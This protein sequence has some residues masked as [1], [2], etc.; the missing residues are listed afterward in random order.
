MTARIRKRFRKLQAGFSLIEIAVAVGILGVAVTGLLIALAFGVR[1]TDAVAQRSTAL[2]IARSQIESIKNQTYTTTPS[3]YATITPP[4]D[5][6]V[7]SIT[8]TELTAG[9]LE[10]VTVSVTYPEGDIELSAYK[11]KHA[12]PIIAEAAL[13]VPTPTPAPG[14]ELVTYYLH[15]NPTP[16]C[17]RYDG[18]S[19]FAVR[20]HG[21]SD[22]HPL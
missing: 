22:F 11:V 2:Q 16:P 17:S 10:Q 20:H 5:D 19:G 13:S 12:P 9:F 1:G 3:A 4:N 14:T 7:I 15:N 6:F 8:G 21:R 18:A